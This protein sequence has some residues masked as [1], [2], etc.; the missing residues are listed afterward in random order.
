M[1]LDS[2]TMWS[3]E[4]HAHSTDERAAYGSIEWSYMKVPRTAPFARQVD[5]MWRKRARARVEGRTGESPN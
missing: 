2:E 5:Q 3:K 1:I 4:L